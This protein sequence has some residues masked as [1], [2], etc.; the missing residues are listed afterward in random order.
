MR[1]LT[2]GGGVRNGNEED[3]DE[4]LG[5]EHDDGGGVS[6]GWLM[7]SKDI[8]RQFYICSYFL[9]HEKPGAGPAPYR[10]QP[11]SHWLLFARLLK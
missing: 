3:S 10:I 9:G 11:P 6:T 7:S 1:E 4:K 5:L 2:D 8:H